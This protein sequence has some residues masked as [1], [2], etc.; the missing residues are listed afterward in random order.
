[1]NIQRADHS[2]ELFLDPADNK[3]KVLIVG[4]FTDCPNNIKT[5]TAEIYDPET[6]TFSYTGSMSMPRADMFSAVLPT[7]KI[8]FAGG[9]DNDG[10]PL[11]LA[12][13]YDPATKKFTLTTPLTTPRACENNSLSFDKRTGNILFTGGWEY[14]PIAPDYRQA[15]ADTVQHVMPVKGA[16]M[17]NSYIEKPS[18]RK[19]H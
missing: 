4:G 9:L 6:G 8:L 15:S 13:L 12:E 1:M 7:G 10:K 2:A 3:P 18:L 5:A 17:L 16:Q 19:V 14:T 11:T